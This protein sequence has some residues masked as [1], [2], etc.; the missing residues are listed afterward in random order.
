MRSAGGLPG[1]LSNPE[2]K[3]INQGFKYGYRYRLNRKGQ[4]E[5]RPDKNDFSHPHDALQYAV[6]VAE[7][8][9]LPA[10][11]AAKRG[12]EI[13]ISRYAWA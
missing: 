2:N 5:V 10:M 3:I 8:N 4:Q 11:Q 13:K 9:Q 12:V 7:G 1:F 6:L